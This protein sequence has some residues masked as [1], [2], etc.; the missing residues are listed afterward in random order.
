L[1]IFIT[2]SSGFIGSHVLRFLSKTKHNILALIR[3]NPNNYGLINTVSGDLNSFDAISNQL[4]EFE[5]DVIIFLSWEGIPDFSGKMCKKNL[6]TAIKYFD[7]IIENTNCKKIIVSGSC[8]EYGKTQGSCKESDPVN[9]E[10]HFTWAKNSLREYLDIKCKQKG[11]VFNWLRIFYVYG[12]NQRDE[13]LVPTLIKS[14]STLGIPQ[15]KT[16]LNKNDFIYVDDIAKLIVKAIDTP[17]PSG[18]YN[19]GSG[20]A[21]SVSDIC[22]IVERQLLGTERITK[23]ILANGEKTATVNFWADMNK[24]NNIINQT[25]KTSLEYGIKHHIKSMGYDFFS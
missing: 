10:S 11:I 2:G 8:F 1:N 25:S 16:P 3:D 13:S 23:Q 5:P 17:M 12:P 18:I 21:S 4:F 22:R 15:I 7:E 9:I 20:T 24:T 6:F 19:A 14:I